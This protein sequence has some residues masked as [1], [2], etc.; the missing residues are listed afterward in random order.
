[1]NKGSVFTNAYFNL[2]FLNEEKLK[3]W[4][5]A[6]RDIDLV[7]KFYVLAVKNDKNNYPEFDSNGNWLFILY[8]KDKKVLEQYINSISIES[9][10]NFTR[11]SKLLNSSYTQEVLATINK[12]LVNLSNKTRFIDFTTKVLKN[13]GNKTKGWYAKFIKKNSSSLNIITALME[14]GQAAGLEIWVSLEKEF[15]LTKPSLGDLK[16]L[17][18]PQQMSAYDFSLKGIKAHFSPIIES[19][20]D[21]VNFCENGNLSQIKYKVYFE[22]LIFQNIKWMEKQIEQVYA[23]L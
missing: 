4:N 13:Y 15:I 11:L 2:P 7:E 21:M 3:I 20:S 9:D 16:K 10:N 6:F 23:G 19:L 22:E 1:M 18:E 14:A 12:T 17:P 5:N 8:D